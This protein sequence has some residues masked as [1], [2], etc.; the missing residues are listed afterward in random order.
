MQGI[1]ARKLHRLD[2]KAKKEVVCALRQIRRRAQAAEPPRKGTT[3]HAQP[4]S[5]HHGRS[6][7][8]LPVGGGHMSSRTK[9][10]ITANERH[11]AFAQAALADTD[12]QP[13]RNILSSGSVM[14]QA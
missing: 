2:P 8:A 4:A 11:E 3:I 7:A 12:S 14:L 10:Y 9:A 5:L 6:P 1:D 13:V